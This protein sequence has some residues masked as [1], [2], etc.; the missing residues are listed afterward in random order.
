MDKE[1]T[2]IRTATMEDIINYKRGKKDVNPNDYLL[3][4]CWCGNYWTP[5]KHNYNQGRSKSCGKHSNDK[6]FIDETGHIY[7]ELT[8][9]YPAENKTRMDSHKFWVCQCSCGNI[10]TVSGKDLRQGK[11]KSCGCIQSK[12]Q[13]KITELLIQHKIPFIREFSFD[14]F[15][16]DKQSPYRFDW[17]IFKDNQ[18]F[19]LLE[20]D[21]EQHFD[22]TNAWY[23]PE[24]DDIK[25]NYCYDNNILLYRI[26]YKEYDNITIDF[27][28]EVIKY[29]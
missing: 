10:I 29:E 27:I 4:Q 24:I 22:K 19:C 21:G 2:V 14:N 26:S 17:A 9:L 7:G 13:K 20:Y 3:C 28:K 8:V 12:G 1:V 5:S 25:N 6:R 11:Q 23:R 15:L 16:T 18:L